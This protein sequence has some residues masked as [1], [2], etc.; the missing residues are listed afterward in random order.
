[1]DKPIC[2]FDSGIGGLTVLK[3]LLS[4]FP[5]EEYIY[6]SDLARVPFGDRTKD[7]IQ[8]IANEIISW[9][10][11]Y[12][13]KAIIMACNTSSSVLFEQGRINPATTVPL[14]GMIKGCAK[15]VAS[16]NFSKVTIWAT[17]LVVESNAYKKE[18]QKINPNLIVEEI[19]CPKLVPIIEDLSFNPQDKELGISQYLEKTSEDSQALVLG[20][21]HYPLVQNELSKLTRLKLID[22]ADYIL[23]DL[24][25]HISTNG[26]FHAKDQ[27]TLYT[28]A[29]KEKVEKF[30][31]LYL[32]KHHKV[33]LVSIDKVHV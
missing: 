21:T 26:R 6:F 31:S 25:K 17:K 8:N 32:G 15:E 5:N 11:R 14:Y 29:Q 4:K 20:C 1:M 30:T 3:K 19:A 24:E 23:K 28:T 9:L 33:N 12:N 27:V 10:H 7:E 16:S 13:P 2:L 22:P 18:I